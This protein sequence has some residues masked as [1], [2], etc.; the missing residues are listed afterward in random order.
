MLVERRRRENVYCKVNVDNVNFQMFYLFISSSHIYFNSSTAQPLFFRD[1]SLFRKPRPI[2][3]GLQLINV[4]N[5][6]DECVRTIGR[7]S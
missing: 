4:D 3:F 5:I 6:C 7:R 2:E 1:V